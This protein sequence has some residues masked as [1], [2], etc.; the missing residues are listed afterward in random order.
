LGRRSLLI[1]KVIINH[2]IS[3]TK[4]NK[5]V[6]QI[7]IFICNSV[8]RDAS[9]AYEIWRMLSSMI[10]PSSSPSIKV[11]CM[12]IRLYPLL[13]QTNRRLYGRIIESLGTYVSHPNAELRVI[14]ASTICELAKKDLITDVND[15]IG[16]IQSFLVDEET[17]IVYF[18]ILSLHHLVVANELEYVIVLKVLNK[19]L[20][21][22]DDSITEILGLDDIVI[23][24][25]VQFLGNGE[26]LD[27]DDDSSESSVEDE[28]AEKAVPPHTLLSISSLCSL[29][30]DEGYLPSVIE[31]QSP[32]IGK[33]RILSE[34]YESLS[35]YSNE[36]FDIDEDLICVDGDNEETKTTDITN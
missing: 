34:I 36:S 4:S 9:C 30:L 18:A 16:W 23:E 20:V 29:A 11:Q 27:D 17:M 3:Q 31:N 10:D 1:L 13:R 35:Q 33:L 26:T 32:G 21:K 2:D 22:L 12:V 28:H 19:K 14:T 25:L 5:N 24:A 7:M 15:V 6:Q 8:A